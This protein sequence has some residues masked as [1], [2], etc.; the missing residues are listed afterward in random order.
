MTNEEV[1]PR[2]TGNT[3]LA[4]FDYGPDASLGFDRMTSA[5]S[6]VPFISLLQALS[7]EVDPKS[8]ERLP[9]AEQGMFHNTVSH[10]L[11]AGDTGF[12]F[13]PC[14]SVHLIVEW[15]PRKA[16]GGLKGIHQPTSQIVVDAIAANGGSIVKLKTKDGNDLVETFYVYGFVLADDGSID[17]IACLAFTSTKIKSYKD[18]IYRLRTAKVKA[19]LFAHRVRVTSVGQ[20]NASGSFYNFKIEPAIDGDVMKSLIPPKDAAG[21]PNP[22]LIAG[23]RLN[24][25]VRGGKRK[26]DVEKQKDAPVGDSDASGVF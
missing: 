2:E 26:A 17:S 20:K 24:D 19:P 11:Y 25:E 15:V 14:E 7:P 5:D 8:E 16:G 22:L 6:S 23:K 10:Q 21:N 18:M 3:D 9:G 12:V 13:V 1:I 4:L